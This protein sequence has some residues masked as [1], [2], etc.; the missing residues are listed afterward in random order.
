MSRSLPPWLSRSRVRPH[1]AKLSIES[2]EERRLLTVSTAFFDDQWALVTDNAPTGL[3]VGDLVNNGISGNGSIA[4]VY[5]QDAF[6]SV[7]IDETPESLAG[8]ATINDAIDNTSSGGTTRIIHAASSAAVDVDRSVRLVGA[9]TISSG[10][11]QM[12]DSDAT[13]SLEG[14]PDTITLSAGD[15]DLSAGEVYLG[16]DDSGQADSITVNGS[17]SLSNVA[18]KIAFGDSVPAVGTE[19]V[20]IH[21]DSNDPVTGTFASLAQ[22]DTFAVG[23][24]TLQIDYAGFDGNDVVLRVTAD[25]HPFTS[26][27]NDN[28]YDVNGGSLD[29]GD[30][31]D[32]RNDTGG[33]PSVSA[34]YETPTLNLDDFYEA[35]YDDLQAA[36]D[37]TAEGGVVNIL[38]GTYS[39]PVSGEVVVSKDLALQGSFTLQGA[40]V[41]DDAPLTLMPAADFGAISLAGLEFSSSSTLRLKA[42][43]QDADLIEV[44]G[45]VSLNG[46]KLDLSWLGEAT[47]NLLLIDNQGSNPVSGTFA[48]LPEGAELLLEGQKLWITYSGGDGN[49]VELII[50]DSTVAAR[51]LFYNNS[52]W[53]D[54]NYGFNND[55]AI[56]PDKSAYLPGD[57]ATFA[58]VSSYSRGIN[59][60][61]VD[62]EGSH[63]NI[64]ANDFFFQVGNNNAPSTWS[65]A[66]APL[67]VSV[68]S[69]AGVSGSD[70]VEL[71]WADGA[72]Q[73]ESLRVAVLSTVNTGLATPDVFYFGSRVGDVFLYDYPGAAATDATDQIQV[74]NNQGQPAYINNPYDFNRD[75]VVNSTDELIARNNQGYTLLMAIEAPPSIPLV[76][77]PSVWH[78]DQNVTIIAGAPLLPDGTIDE[79]ITGMDFY[80]D[81]NGNGVLD[82]ADEL[83]AE[84]EELFDDDDNFVGWQGVIDPA[85]LD[86]GSAKILIVARGPDGLVVGTTEQEFEISAQDAA[87]ATVQLINIGSLISAGTTGTFGGAVA[88]NNS[89]NPIAVALTSGAGGGGGAGG[90]NWAMA[91]V[92]VNGGTTAQ[93]IADV[94]ATAGAS[95]STGTINISSSSFAAYNVAYQ[96]TSPTLPNG[97]PV[98]I[99]L[100]AVG[101]SFAATTGTPVFAV[102]TTGFSTT[103]PAGNPAVIAA[104]SVVFL[105]P[106]ELINAIDTQQTIPAR[107]G[108][109]IIVTATPPNQGLNAGAYADA[110]PLG[111]LNTATATSF[112]KI[113]LWRF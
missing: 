106:G 111:P 69:G 6:G 93:V 97:F 91:T 18:L 16:I 70:R 11:L 27:V 55:S 47:G 86:P 49:D 25:H 68:R 13:I 90:T 24:Y 36:I 84:G 50:P 28:W 76:S 46:A 44:D 5:G 3:S 101:Y 20:I 58:S 104:G 45:D 60:I 17:V 73:N 30:P 21:N 12:S 33:A 2:L 54:P 32:D 66:P 79:D 89:P 34:Y 31:V 41:A 96:I 100:D 65:N 10:D 112:A 19:Y 99:G 85:N 108:Q 61:M 29:A 75:A 110:S 64:T 87:N 102:A 105:E 4:A 7:I 107:I 81:V 109:V 40:L 22:D 71:V 83:L 14:S 103:I 63:P 9:L 43:P 77:A 88:I 53:D 80:R 15:L 42:T 1:A 59:G 82:P 92:Q 8:A 35:A 62:I 94:G 72:I 98:R 38:P 74:R 52:I 39:P 23:E 67:A 48:G 51:H 95:A 113:A 57:V 78:R 56:A 26:Y 37:A